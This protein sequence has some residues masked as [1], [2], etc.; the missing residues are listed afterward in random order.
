MGRLGF[1]SEDP[2]ECWGQPFRMIQP[3]T[4]HHCQDPEQGGRAQAKPMHNREGNLAR[5]ELLW[6]SASTH[7][8][9]SGGQRQRSLA[10]QKIGLTRSDPGEGPTLVR[11]L[12]L[13]PR[14][15]AKGLEQKMRGLTHTREMLG[16]GDGFRASQK[17]LGDNWM[18]ILGFPRN[19]GFPRIV[20]SHYRATIRKNRRDSAPNGRSKVTSEP[21]PAAASPRFSQP[22][23]TRSVRAWSW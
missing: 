4:L 12:P 20:R 7:R 13:L 11:K 8:Q 15:E 2:W 21:D 5:T 10:P 19:P 17:Q 1:R 16:F 23:D 6:T 22:P 18:T 9:G 3:A 14:G